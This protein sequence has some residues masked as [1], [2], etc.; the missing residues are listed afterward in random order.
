MCQTTETPTT[1]VEII[2]TVANIATALTFAAAAWQLYESNRQTKKAAIQKRSEYIIDLYDKFVNDDDMI[3]VYYSIEYLEFSYNPTE[4]FP[5]QDFNWDPNFH[6]TDTEKKLDKLLG[7]FSNIGRLFC[8]KILTND[9]LQFLK[10]EFLIIYQNENIK[11]YLTFLDN[12]FRVRKIMDKK[13][14]Y[15]R[16]AAE[17]LEKENNS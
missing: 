10:Y 2:Q 1:A 7:H 15:F 4:R 9:D 11:A 13:F 17:I 6:G 12:W 3:E 14:A 8:S 5:N 16:T